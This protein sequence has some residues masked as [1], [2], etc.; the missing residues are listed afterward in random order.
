MT[1]EFH[2]WPGIYKE[3]SKMGLI[4]ESDKVVVKPQYDVVFS[5]SY[6]LTAVGKDNYRD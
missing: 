6:R 1:E 2:K 3:K 4:N 5:I